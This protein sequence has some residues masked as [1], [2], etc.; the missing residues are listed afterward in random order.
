MEI[1][2]KQESILDEIMRIGNL[3]RRYIDKASLAREQS[4][5]G[6]DVRMLCYLLDHGEANP[7]EQRELERRLGLARS[8]V[9]ESLSELE[10]CGMVA[11]EPMEGD[12]RQK[13][14]RLTQKAQEEEAWM[15]AQQQRLEQAVFQEFTPE[16]QAQFHSYLERTIASLARQREKRASKHDDQEER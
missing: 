13:R 15:Q 5:S 16:E 1:S 2:R 12:A 6:R 14:V 11:R 7:M 3:L 10:R 9:S 4:L 8:T